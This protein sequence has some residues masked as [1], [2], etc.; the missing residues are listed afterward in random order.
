[1]LLTLTED[2]HVNQ[3]SSVSL[4]KAAGLGGNVATSTVRQ[5]H[6]TRFLEMIGDRNFLAGRTVGEKYLGRE[7][8]EMGYGV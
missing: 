8:V 4:L 3:P 7:T 6:P 1:M 5:Q 2:H